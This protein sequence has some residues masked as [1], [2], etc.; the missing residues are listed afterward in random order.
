MAVT[1]HITL[2]CDKCGRR[3]MSPDLPPPPFL[4]LGLLATAASYPFDCPRCEGVEINDEGEQRA[5]YAGPQ[6]AS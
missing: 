6:A 5:I 1:V 2:V 3:S 4:T